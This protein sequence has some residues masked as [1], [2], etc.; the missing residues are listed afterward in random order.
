MYTCRLHGVS[1]E[2]LLAPLISRLG[3]PL[4]RTSGDNYVLYDHDL[5]SYALFDMDGHQVPQELVTKVR[6]AFGCIL[7]EENSMVLML[8]ESKLREVMAMVKARRKC[9]TTMVKAR[10]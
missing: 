8:N 9:T 10:G 4:Y 6:E 1:K 7:K 3:L 5:E 2:N